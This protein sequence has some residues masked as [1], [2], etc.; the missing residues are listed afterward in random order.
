RR[1][2]KEFG[3]FRHHPHGEVTSSAVYYPMTKGGA[4][5]VYYRE[6]A[7]ACNRRY[8]DALAVVDD[9]TPAYQD[10]RQLTEPKVVEGRSY[11]GFNPARRDDVHLFAAGLAGGPIPRGVAGGG[12]PAAGCWAPT[13]TPPPPP[14]TPP[15]RP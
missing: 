10:L 15:R 6:Q 14:P 4:S 7:L 3:V 11:A 8:L 9:P 1:G 12:N 13:Q 5:W 2:R